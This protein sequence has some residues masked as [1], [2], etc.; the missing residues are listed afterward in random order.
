VNVPS[1]ICDSNG[2]WLGVRPTVGSQSR[3][4][5]PAMRLMKKLA[6]IDIQEMYPAGSEPKAMLAIW[7]I[8]S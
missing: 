4:P 8:C 6:N 1:N 5:A 2:K 3:A 7:K